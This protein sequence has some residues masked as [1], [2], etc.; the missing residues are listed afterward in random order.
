[1]RGVQNENHIRVGV[2]L[3]TGKAQWGEGTDARELLDFAVRAEE[4][5]YASIWVNDSLLSPRIE[6]LSMLSAL[7]P[8]TS[9]ATLGTATLMPV[10]RRPIQAAQALAS[11]DLLSGGRLIV[12]VGAGFPGRLGQPLYELSEVPWA[13]RFERLDDTIRLWRHLWTTPGPSSFAGQVLHYDALPPTTQPY[14]PGGPPIWL[15]GATPAATARTGRLYDGWLPYP[16]APGAYAAGWTAVRDSAREAGRAPDILTPGLYLT[17]LIADSVEAGRQ[18]LDAYT[19]ATYGTPLEVL[20]TIQL[21]VAGPREVVRERLAP[22][23]AAGAR[24]LVCRIG[25]LSLQ[26]Q[27]EQLE[28]ILDV[29]SSRRPSEHDPLSAASSRPASGGSS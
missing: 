3:P 14:Q 20:E 17:V 13:G 11:I 22:Y 2:L 7:A 10:L 12:G 18:S 1:M 8:L 5:G 26:A 15:G 29:L 23:L 28:P 25:A 19:H 27:A 9:R 16:P 6:G 24:H 21:L 4:L